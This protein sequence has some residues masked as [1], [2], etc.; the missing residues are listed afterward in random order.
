MIVADSNLL[1]YL[2]IPGEKSALSERILQRDPLWAAPLLCRSELRNI[3]ALYMRH[4]G[5]SLAEAQRSMETAEIVLGKREYAVPSD[6]VL[7]LTARHAATA[8]D[9]EFV[10]LARQLGVPLITFDEPLRK[11]FSDV[12]I[13]PQDFVT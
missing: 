2:L 7:A 1:A 12:A 9:A 13:D 4:R 5:M 8:H 6:E 11:T 10:V 3:L